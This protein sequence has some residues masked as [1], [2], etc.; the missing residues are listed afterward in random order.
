MDAPENHE[1]LEFPER[2]S[3]AFAEITSSNSNLE[4][5][6]RIMRGRSSTTVAER[7]DLYRQVLLDQIHEEPEYT[8]VEDRVN[9]NAP[10]W[11]DMNLETSQGKWGTPDGECKIFVTIP[12]A[13]PKFSD[14]TL[15]KAFE[16]P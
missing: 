10:D 12:K 14:T 7:A 1:S 2:G 8:I 4:K 16:V 3:A 11:L 6:L 15:F 9:G 5:F 13:I